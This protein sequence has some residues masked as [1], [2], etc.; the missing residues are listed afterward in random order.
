MPTLITR[1]T[2]RLLGKCMHAVPT[3]AIHSVGISAIQEHLY[4]VE[5]QEGFTHYSYMCRNVGICSFAY[6]CY[7]KTYN[8]AC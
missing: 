5:E 4:Y 8:R 6:D 1:Q 3:L 2:E 7:R